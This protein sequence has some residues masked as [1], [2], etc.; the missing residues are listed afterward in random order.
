[1]LVV[2]QKGIWLQATTQL[3]HH[4]TGGEQ[5]QMRETNDFLQ[6][7]SLKDHHHN[8]Q[9]ITVTVLKEQVGKLTYAALLAVRCCQLGSLS[10]LLRQLEYAAGLIQADKPRLEAQAQVAQEGVEKSQTPSFVLCT[11]HS[12]QGKGASRVQAKTLIV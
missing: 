5:P 4:H 9:A 12:N 6:G 10:R 3:V 7:Q 1:M 2:D 8:E 11:D